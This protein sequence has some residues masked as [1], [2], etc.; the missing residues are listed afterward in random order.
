MKITNRKTMAVAVLA[1][2]IATAAA[3]S[4]WPRHRFDMV[5]ELASLSAKKGIWDNL[6]DKPNEKIT[7]LKAALEAEENTPKRSQLRR[8][9]AQR[10]LYAN[11]VEAA[12]GTLEELL[13][14][15]DATV[16]PEWVQQIKGDGGGNHLFRNLGPDERGMPKFVD[17]TRSAGVAEPLRSFACW[18][19]DFNNDGWPDIFVRGYSTDLPNI[20]REYLGD[21]AHAQ[22]ERPRLYRNNKDGTFTDVAREAGVDWLLLPMG[23]NFGD[24]DNDGWLDFYIGT[25]DPS[26]ET[27]VPNRMFRNHLGKYFEDVTTSGGFGHLQKGHGIA[28]GDIDNDGNQDVVSELGGAFT[29]DKFWTAIYKNPGHANHWIKLNL[30]GVKAN[31]FAVGGRIRLAITEAGVAREIFYTVGS[32]GS[33]GGN[34]LRPHIGV[35]KAG[36]VDLLE[37]AWPGSGTVQQFKGPIPVDRTYSIVEGKSELVPILTSTAIASATR[38]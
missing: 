31:R 19:F 4:A 8:E 20:V 7:A 15:V 28:F 35:G 12:V 29:S 17:V 37:I 5:T 30:V 33:F 24:L 26:L 11:S 10:Y 14:D 34:N 23:V 6:W 16:P 18:F 22:G 2:F 25:G 36:S 32:G 9:L 27:L 38:K 13:Q 1:L 21:K 3:Y